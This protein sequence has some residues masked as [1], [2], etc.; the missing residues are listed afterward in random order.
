MNDDLIE[1]LRM[2]DMSHD[3]GEYWHTIDE[4]ADRIEELEADKALMV[5][6]FGN[7]M[8]DRALAY[9]GLSLEKLVAENERLRGLLARALQAMNLEGKEEQ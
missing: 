9:A 7:I 5:Q 4:A 3:N 1:R 6:T 2:I 8:D